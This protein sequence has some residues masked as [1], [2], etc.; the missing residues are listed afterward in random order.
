MAQAKTTIFHTIVGT[1]LSTNVHSTGL[2]RHN[3][4]RMSFVGVCGAWLATYLRFDLVSEAYLSR[5]FLS[6]K[7][8][9]DNAPIPLLLEC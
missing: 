7:I 5:D 8:A 4:R 3:M 2:H 6:P 9:W 1:E